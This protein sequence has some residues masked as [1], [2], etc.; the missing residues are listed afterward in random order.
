MAQLTAPPPETLPEFMRRMRKRRRLTQEQAA[1]GLDVDEK[2]YTN[3]EAGKTVPPVRFAS[4]AKLYGVT[5]GVVAMLAAG[6][7]PGAPP[8]LS[9]AQG[10]WEIVAI[11]D[12]VRLG[13]DDVD[14]ANAGDGPPDTGARK[15]RG[16]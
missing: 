13:A 15:R 11:V 16:G 8:G 4:I 14:A 10:F 1:D 9:D 5:E 7:D 6:R 2:T 12:R 3:Y